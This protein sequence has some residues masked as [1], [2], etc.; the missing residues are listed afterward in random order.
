M[1]RRGRP[2]HLHRSSDTPR[3]DVDSLTDLDLSYTPPFGAPWDA[4]QD[5]AQAWGA[6]LGVEGVQ[7]SGASGG[8]RSARSAARADGRR[9]VARDDARVLFELDGVTATRA[10]RAVFEG[11][12]AALADGAMGIVGASGVGKST[13]LRLLN[14]S[15]I[16][17]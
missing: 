10:G 12:D 6:G 8:R 14:R 13:L 16:R 4:V 7:R 15:P 11:L 2:H 1:A 17:P 9:A 5:A 3:D